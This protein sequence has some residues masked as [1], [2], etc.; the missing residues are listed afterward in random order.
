MLVKRQR[1][2]N[3]KINAPI[4]KLGLGGKRGYEKIGNEEFL[5]GN[6]DDFFFFLTLS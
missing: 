3:F 6:S 1:R 2:Y 4:L 5:P